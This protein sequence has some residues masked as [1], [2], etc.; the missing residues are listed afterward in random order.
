MGIGCSIGKPGLGW[1]SNLTGLQSWQTDS[2][3]ISAE[4]ARLLQNNVVFLVVSQLGGPKSCFPVLREWWLEK[5]GDYV[6]LEQWD[7]AEVLNDR[8][9]HRLEK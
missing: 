7:G 6:G 9:I 5:Y 2:V 4:E 8:R 1:G 3:G